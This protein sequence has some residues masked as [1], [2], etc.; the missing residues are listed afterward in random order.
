MGNFTSSLDPNYGSG[1]VAS[2]MSGV[3]NS[4]PVKLPP[5]NP[6]ID[7][8]VYSPKQSSTQGASFNPQSNSHNYLQ[9]FGSGSHF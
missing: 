8:M 4:P 3:D 6:F 1:S 7:P 5:I 9:R 2:D